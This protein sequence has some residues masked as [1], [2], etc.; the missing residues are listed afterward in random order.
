MYFLMVS[1]D[2]FPA[3]P[4]YNWDSTDVLSKV[5]RV[6]QDVSKTIDMNLNLEFPS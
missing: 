5:Y 1:A 3:D 4:T 2:T 6:E